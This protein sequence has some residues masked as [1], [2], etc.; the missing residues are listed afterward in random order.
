MI[1]WI[2]LGRL[3]C[4]VFC[5]LDLLFQKE[6]LWEIWR[7]KSLYLS[8]ELVQLWQQLYLPVGL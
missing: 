1:V 2:I 6:Y 5:S 8:T 3:I 4:F 7:M